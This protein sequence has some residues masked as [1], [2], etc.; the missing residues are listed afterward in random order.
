MLYN[1][2]SY[3]IIYLPGSAR[4][5][6]SSRLASPT[7]SRGRSAAPITTTHYDYYYL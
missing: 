3:Y 7:P 2:L 1:S 4:M 5:P 6:S